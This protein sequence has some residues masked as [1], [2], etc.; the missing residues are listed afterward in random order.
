MKI[1]PL[2]VLVG[3]FI[4]I[5][6]RAQ[7]A[8]FTGD[9]TEVRVVRSVEQHPG[10]SLLWEPSI[11]EWKPKY[12]VVAFGAGI[13]GKTDMGDIYASVSTDDGEKWSEPAYIFNHNERYGA[14]QFAYANPVI[15]KPPGQ[16]VLWCFAIRCPMS[17]AHSEDSHLAA[18]YS[19]DGG[20]SWNPVELAMHYT[21]PLITVSGGLYRIV[22]NG[23]PRYLMPVHRNTRRNDPLGTRDL[24]VL[25]ST[26]LLEW[27]LAGYVPPPE[28]GKV[29]LQE[30]NIS[31]DGDELH[32]MMRAAQYEDEG[33]AVDPPTAFSSVSKDGGRTW[34][35]ARAEPDLWNTNAKAF[36]GQTPDGT[37]FYIYSDGPARSRMALRY[38]LQPPGGVWSAEKTFYDSGTHNSYPTLL[39]TAPGEFRAVWD[40]GTKDRARTHI[41]FGKFRV[42]PAAK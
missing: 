27:S 2:I 24:F 40:S 22:E 21:G 1:P 14:L 32:L 42:P 41:C 17:Y 38:K 20:R 16:D 37:H 35:P 19:G 39:E 36:Y 8:S 30:G 7:D 9:V 11:A 15:Y 4:P 31:V 5:P 18:A 23:Q 25:S 33:K 29:F 10:A 6:G 3:L 34:S 13:P 26:S 28:S 12:L